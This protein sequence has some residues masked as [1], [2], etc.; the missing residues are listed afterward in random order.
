MSA[1]PDFGEEYRKIAHQMRV[2][3]GKLED[4]DLGKSE[5]PK[6]EDSLS[7]V[8][9]P[10][11]PDLPQEEGQKLLTSDTPVTFSPGLD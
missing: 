8:K 3:A 10:L 7:S 9:R 4:S 1:L 11:P 5:D 6:L 2:E